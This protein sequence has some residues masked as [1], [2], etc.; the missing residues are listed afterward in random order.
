M[1]KAKYITTENPWYTNNIVNYHKIIYHPENHS[2]PTGQEFITWWDDICSKSSK[3]SVAHLQEKISKSFLD[4]QISKY[5]QHI[6]EDEKLVHHFDQVCHKGSGLFLQA[7]PKSPS[8]SF[9]NSEFTKAVALRL[10]LPIY[11]P[12]KSDQC[13]CYRKPTLDPY[14]H[15]FLCCNV[16]GNVIIDMMQSNRVFLN[17]INKPE[18]RQF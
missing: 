1:L 17:Y 18:L 13:R 5:R 12:T 7:V 9:S 4:S 16:G 11:Q 15:H 2:T 14:G 8:L 6:K 3:Q 10:H